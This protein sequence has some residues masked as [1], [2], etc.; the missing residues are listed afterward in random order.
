MNTFVGEFTIMLGA[1]QAAPVVAVLAGVGVVLA[2][3]Y[4]LRLHQGVMQEPLSPVAERSAD[5]SLREGLVMVPMVVLM[6]AIGLF[7]HP[8]GALS[9]NNVNQYISVVNAPPAQTQANA[10]Q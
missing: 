5:L 2:C 4:M 8:F 7:P 9:Q 10:G 1:F 6:L 3:W